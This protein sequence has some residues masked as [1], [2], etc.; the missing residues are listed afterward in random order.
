MV[1]LNRGL[2]IHLLL[3]TLKKQGKKKKL[4]ENV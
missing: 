3:I 1:L 4:K 2:V